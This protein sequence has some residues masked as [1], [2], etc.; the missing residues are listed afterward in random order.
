MKINLLLALMY[1]GK[2]IKQLDSTIMLHWY[3]KYCVY[4]FDYNYVYI[5]LMYKIYCRSSIIIGVIMKRRIIDGK[6]QDMILLSFEVEKNIHKAMRYIALERDT[7]LRQLVIRSVT[8]F[9]EKERALGNLEELET[10]V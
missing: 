1:H 9:V 7:S 10:T 4:L 5:Y 8:E 2:R 3:K 6:S